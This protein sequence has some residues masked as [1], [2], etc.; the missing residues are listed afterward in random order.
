MEKL[1]CWQIDGE[2]PN[3]NLPMYYYST[4]NPMCPLDRD[5]SANLGEKSYPPNI[6]PANNY[7]MPY[8][9]WLQHQ[10]YYTCIYTK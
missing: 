6:T 9:S 2:L 4:G 7:F 1:I 3:Y 10:V 5:Q 8:R